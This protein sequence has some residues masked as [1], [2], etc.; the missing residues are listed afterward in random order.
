MENLSANV[1]IRS[2]RYFLKDQKTENMGCST[3]PK[4]ARAK[5]WLVIEGL[6]KNVISSFPESFLHP[7]KKIGGLTSVVWN[8]YDLL[9]F[10]FQLLKSLDSGSGSRS[11]CRQYL[12]V[13]QQT[14]NCTKNT[15]PMSGL[16]KHYI[17]EIWTLIFDF[18]FFF[19]SFYVESGSKSGSGGGTRPKTASGNGTVVHSG[20]GSAKAQRYGSCGSGVPPHK[21]A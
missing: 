19:I 1:W 20:S 17:P 9:R 21:T 14:W 16:K 12:S 11:G 10:L 4:F 18:F 13:F 5:Q 3:T 8:R 6:G 15:F 2:T 7:L